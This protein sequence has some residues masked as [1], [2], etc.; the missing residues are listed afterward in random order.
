[1]VEL[2]EWSKNSSKPPMFLVSETDGA[3]TAVTDQE[4]R[5]ESTR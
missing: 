1:M 3:D 2:H 5:A 4:R